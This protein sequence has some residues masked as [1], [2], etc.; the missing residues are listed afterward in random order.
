VIRHYNIIVKGKVQGVSYRFAAHAMALKLSLTGLVRNLPNGD[1][2][3]EAEGAEENINKMIEWC[4]IGPPLAKV[5]EVAAEEQEVKG[6]RNFELK[7]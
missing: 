6:Y 1:V 3:I 7:R 4:Y 5:K 2:Y